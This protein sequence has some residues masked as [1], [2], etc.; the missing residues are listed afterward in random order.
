MLHPAVQ[1]PTFHRVFRR[2]DERTERLVVRRE[3]H[4]E[5]A[6]VVTERRGP[7]PAP[8]DGASLHVVLRRV[9]QLVE[10]IARQLPVHQILGAHHRRT[11]HQ[12]HRRAHHVKV[13]AH[14]NHV[15]IGQIRPQHRIGKSRR[16]AVVR[17]LPNI[18][19]CI[20]QGHMGKRDGQRQ[21]QLEYFAFV[22]TKN[23]FNVFD[24]F[25]HFP[26]IEI[27]QLMGFLPLEQQIQ[28]VYA[29]NG[30]HVGRELLPVLPLAGIGHTERA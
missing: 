4:V 22:H 28:V 10:D 1:S 14:A 8:I 21:R 2:I 18:L 13:I 15:R 25:F 24:L 9:M 16:M 29:A 12:V 27:E 5:L 23:A 3:Q 6:V 11:G 19:G 17:R 30:F 7:L 20:C 26:I